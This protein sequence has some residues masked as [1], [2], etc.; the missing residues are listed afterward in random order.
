MRQH[1]YFIINDQLRERENPLTA[2]ALYQIGA[3]R[4]IFF[5]YNALLSQ[6][7]TGPIA[8]SIVPF[9]LFFV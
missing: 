1:W 9:V 4:G 8:L 5:T 6:N 3:V 2:P 7:S